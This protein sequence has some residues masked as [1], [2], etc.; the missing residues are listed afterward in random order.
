MPVL[1]ALAF[2]GTSL[3]VGILIFATLTAIGLV[4]R[5][6]LE[7]LRLLLLPRVGG[8]LTVVVLLMVALSVISNELGFEVAL[9]VA[10][11]PMVVITMMIERTALMWEEVG[12][13][14][15]LRQWINGTLGAVAVY[16]VITPVSLGYFLLLFPETLLIVLAAMILLG[17]YTG[18]RLTEIRRFRD[19]GR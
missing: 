9:S 12:P 8:V 10:L 14:D 19:V 4:A 2:R 3:M 17:R 6:G 16:Y 13:K 5:S 11:F 15:A 1:L 18:Y 7:R